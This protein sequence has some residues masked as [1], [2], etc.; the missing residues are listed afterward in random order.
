MQKRELIKIRA[1]VKD[2]KNMK[3]MKPKVGYFK[4]VCVYVFWCLFVF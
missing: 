4:F 2:I 3:E 1:E